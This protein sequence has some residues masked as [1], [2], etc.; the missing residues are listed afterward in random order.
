M[1]NDG[2]EISNY[3]EAMK[4]SKEHFFSHE[5]ALSCESDSMFLLR[6]SS[7]E[8]DSQLLIRACKC[9]EHWNTKSKK[10]EIF[11][12]HPSIFNCNQH[13]GA[14]CDTKLIINNN[15]QDFIFLIS[16]KSRISISS[17]TLHYRK[18]SRLS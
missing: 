14:L 12:K 4:I 5:E 13:L 11:Q 7:I 9:C 6:S 3:Q 2:D 15:F 10:L 16:D 8:Q 18:R 17:S 1:L